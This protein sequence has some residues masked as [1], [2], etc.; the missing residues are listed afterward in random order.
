M[1]TDK[2][3]STSNIVHP[4]KDPVLNEE[5][6]FDSMMSRFD[7]AAELLSLEPGIYKVLRHAEKQITV[8]CPI[9]LDNGEVEVF[10]GHRV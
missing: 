4:D 1:A 5:N 9:V 10:T 7:H 3:V 6:P 8:S 2:R